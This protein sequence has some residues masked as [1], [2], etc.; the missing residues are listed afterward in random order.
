MS[1]NCAPAISAY[2]RRQHLEGLIA[3]VQG[4]DP[5]DVKLMKPH[6]YLLTTN[7]N[8]SWFGRGD[9]IGR[10]GRCL[11]VIVES[12]STAARVS[13]RVDAGSTGRVGWVDGLVGWRV[14]RVR[15][16]G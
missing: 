1:N 3:H 16:V 4:R 6:P 11:G 7:P 14:S 10:C 13:S 2:L 15:G 9:W 5:D 8:L 12:G